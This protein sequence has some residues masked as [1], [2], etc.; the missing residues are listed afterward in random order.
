MQPFSTYKY[1][2][3]MGIKDPG[4][5]LRRLRSIRHIALDMDGTIYNGN[6]LFPFTVPFLKTL[7]QLG[8]TCSFLTNNPSKSIGD[9]LNHLKRMGIPATGEE[10]YTSAQATVEHLRRR[11]PEVRRLFILGTPAMIS[12]FE[13]AGFEMAADAPDDRPDAVVVGFDLSLV[14][15]RLCRAAWWIKKGLP[16]IATNPDRVCPTD[17]PTLLV[18]CGSL[19]A[20]LAEATGRK[21]DFIAGK[22]DPGMLQ[23][24]I[25][26]YG[27]LT[28]QIAMVG[29][30][31]Y[32]D[33]KMA[34]DA[35]ALGILVLSGETRLEDVGKY[36]VTPDL[37]TDDLASLSGLLLEANASATESR[38]LP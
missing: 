33:M 6:T 13:K 26:R 1:L 31:L 12:E 36:A 27:L 2:P 37:I 15:S 20:C 11:L 22:P 24:I 19:C 23:G 18:D 34:A 14:Y 21:P 29:D 16:F 38:P 35:R 28:F 8:I 17:Q 9:Y 7:K 25:E 3:R 4:E 32:T 5:L 10:L 30:R